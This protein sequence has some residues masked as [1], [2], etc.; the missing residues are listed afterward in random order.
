MPLRKKILIAGVALTA[1]GAVL[2]TWFLVKRHGG[3]DGWQ[4]SVEGNRILSE[5]DVQDVVS[6]LLKAAKDGVSSDE[7]RDALLFN[8][9]IATAK[10]TV[11]PGR[12]VNITV[13]ERQLEYLQSEQE[14]VAEKDPSARQS[15]RMP[16]IY[17]KISLQTKLFST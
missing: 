10:V 7:I 17:T 2:T 13:T 15:S 11:L 12:R 9:R 6:Y 8:P 4:I 5:K 3:G 1:L 16:R 14:G